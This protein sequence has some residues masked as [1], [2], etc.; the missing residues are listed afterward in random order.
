MMK[1]TVIGDTMKME[2]GTMDGE[3]M[4]KAGKVMVKGGSAEDAAMAVAKDRAK[5]AMM[6]KAGTMVGTKSAPVQGISAPLQTMPVPAG[7]TLKSGQAYSAPSNC[8]SGTTA[9]PDGTCM[10]TGNYNPG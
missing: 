9:Q 10:I 2:K 5:D 6:E 1:E 7:A 3:E 4:M 8:P